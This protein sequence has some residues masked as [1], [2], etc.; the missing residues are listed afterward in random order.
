MLTGGE[1]HAWRL[2]QGWTQA[3]AAKML[4][5]GERT[6]RGA[7]ATPDEPLGRAILA[8]L[9]RQVTGRNPADP[10]G[11]PAGRTGPAGIRQT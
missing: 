5:V 7:E 3:Q 1:L 6:I 2:A 10:A 11:L 4:G 8:G 9:D